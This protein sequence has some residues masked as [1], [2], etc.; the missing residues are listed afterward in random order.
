MTEVT[1]GGDGIHYFDETVV[2]WFNGNCACK[3]TMVTISFLNNNTNINLLRL[4]C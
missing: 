1:Q 3:E 4:P 2:N